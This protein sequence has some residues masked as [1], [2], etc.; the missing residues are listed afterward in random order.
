MPNFIEYS[1]AQTRQNDYTYPY[2]T[3]L[4]KSTPPNFTD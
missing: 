3:R 4:L 1:R 2:L